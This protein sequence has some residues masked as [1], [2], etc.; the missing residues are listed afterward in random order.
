MYTGDL[1]LDDG[2][3]RSVYDL[4]TSNLTPIA[5]KGS[6][7]ESITLEP[8]DTVDIPGGLGTLELGEIKQF[9]SFDVHHDP[10]QEWVF[11]FAVLI[12]GGIL[13]GLFIPRRRVWVKIIDGPTER[14]VEFAGLAR[15]DDPRLDDAVTAVAEALAPSAVSVPK[16]KVEK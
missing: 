3:G 4:D 11:V 9:A 6:A 13:T 14:S 8:G 1:G 15:G 12:L 10:S 7:V 5:G 16:T 2:I